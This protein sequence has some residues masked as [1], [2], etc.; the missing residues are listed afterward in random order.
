MKR[1]IKPVKIDKN[2]KDFQAYKFIRVEKDNAKKAGARAKRAEEAANKDKWE[3]WVD[4]I[5]FFFFFFYS[6]IIWKKKKKNVFFK[7]F[8]FIFVNNLLNR[9]FYFKLKM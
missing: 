2:M 6:Y 3:K 1:R 9:F 4:N 5:S 8:Y 7:N